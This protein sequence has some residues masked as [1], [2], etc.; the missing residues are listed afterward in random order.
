M[1][2]TRRKGIERTMFPEFDD[3]ERAIVEAL[4]KH[5]DSQANVLSTYTGLPIN[6]IV[7][8]LFTLE[9]KGVVMSLA[10]NTYHLIDI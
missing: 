9:M 10:G 4:K 1:E 5:G 7:S 2:D 6:M 3:N 8:S